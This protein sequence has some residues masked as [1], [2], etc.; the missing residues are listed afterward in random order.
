[1]V[2]QQSI[3]AGVPYCRE[4]KAVSLETS[5]VQIVDLLIAGSAAIYTGGTLHMRK[6]IPQ[7]LIQKPQILRMGFSKERS[8]RYR[9][10]A[11][12]L[13]AV[14]SQCAKSVS[15]LIDLPSRHQG[16]SSFWMIWNKLIIDT[17]WLNE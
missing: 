13:A 1:M 17:V 8:G 4:K 16:C 6:K 3:P 5:T 15:A 12:Y 7:N 2:I 11:R 10:D 14:I 9:H